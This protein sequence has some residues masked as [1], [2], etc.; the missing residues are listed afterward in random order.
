M[1]VK[2]AAETGEAEWQNGLTEPG[3]GAGGYTISYAGMR[4]RSANQGNGTEGSMYA[5]V[6]VLQPGGSRAAP[7]ERLTTKPYVEYFAQYMD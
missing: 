4:V 7:V 2:T 3:D 1:P 6:E 5:R